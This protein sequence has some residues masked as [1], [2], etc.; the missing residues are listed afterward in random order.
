VTTDDNALGRRWVNTFDAPR[1]MT[2]RVVLWHS[3]T[4]GRFIDQIGAFACGE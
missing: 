1:Q 4:A 2:E 3:V